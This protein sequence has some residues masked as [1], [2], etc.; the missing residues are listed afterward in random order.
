MTGLR[1]KCPKCGKVMDITGPTSCACGENLEAFP[2][3]LKLYRKGSPI[4]VAVPYGVYFNDMPWGHL[5]NTETGTYTLP[6]GTYRIHITLGA[7]RRCKDVVVEIT[8]ENPVAC[9]KAWVKPGFW[10]NTII[11]DPCNESEIPN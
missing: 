5:A 1:I 4:G 2:G 8:P 3:T 6:Y 10:S 11:I 9:F 7:T